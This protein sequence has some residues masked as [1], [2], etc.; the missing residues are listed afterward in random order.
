LS[1]GISGR[2][3]ERTSANEMQ[4]AEPVSADVEHLLSLSNVNIE[5]KSNVSLSMRAL[6]RALN[7]PDE[8]LRRSWPRSIR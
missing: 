5:A 4:G 1:C 3:A 7:A 8:L 2:G 6:Q